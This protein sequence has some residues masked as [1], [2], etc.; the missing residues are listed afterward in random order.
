MNKEVKFAVAIWLVLMTF[1]MNHTL[2]E[3]RSH[4]FWDHVQYTEILVNKH[5]LPYPN[6]G[7]ETYQPP[8]Y[9]I[10]NSFVLPQAMK[11]NLATHINLVRLLSIIYGVLALFLISSLISEV[12]NNIIAKILALMFIA[13]TPTYT[14]IFSTYNNDSLMTLLCIGL[15]FIF[16]KLEGNWS[17]KNAFILYILATASLYTKITSIVCIGSLFFICMKNLF[18]FKLP[19]KLQIKIMG[20]LFLSIVSLLPWMIFHNYKHTDKLIPSNDTTLK[21]I[22]ILTK[23]RKVLGL[24]LKDEK[25]LG[26]K[27][28][29]SHEWEV[30]WVYPESNNG[31]EQRSTKKYDYIGFTFITSI[32]GE[33][34]LT[35]PHVIF[36][37]II[38]FIHLMAYISGLFSTFNSEITKFAGSIILFSTFCHIILFSPYAE[39]YASFIDYRYLGWNWMLWCILYTSLLVNK[40]KILRKSSKA[41]LIIGIFTQ[42]YIMISIEG[43]YWW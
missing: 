34:V 32:I 16:K 36:I 30:P 23:H 20:L 37:W 22:S 7:W 42:S 26:I 28:D 1:Y 3:E 21:N 33:Y 43:G 15:V 12:T 4:D 10:I 31:K 14:F 24:L 6:E 29:F 2:P 40:N 9:Y 8:L 27:H 17:S 5:R 39:F 41:I 18:I 35:K 25:L 13:T 38:L 11:D 19:S